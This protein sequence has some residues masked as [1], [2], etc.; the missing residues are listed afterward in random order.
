MIGKQ[1]G[2]KL[3][4]RTHPTKN[5][6]LYLELSFTIQYENGNGSAAIAAATY[7][8]TRRHLIRGYS[9]QRV[10]PCNQTVNDAETV[11]WIKTF[12]EA[13]VFMKGAALRS[14]FVICIH[15]TSSLILI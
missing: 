1:L 8:L 3:G 12:E 11:E 15:Q 5:H 6:I 14:L 2:I 9:L 4:V 13:G 10:I 7:M